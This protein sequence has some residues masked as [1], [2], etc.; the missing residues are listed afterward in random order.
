MLSMFRVNVDPF[1]L[2]LKAGEEL[3]DTPFYE[4]WMNL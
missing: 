1:L 2:G 3:L 4:E